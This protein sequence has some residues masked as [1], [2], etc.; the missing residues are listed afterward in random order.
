MLP[1]GDVVQAR[2]QEMKREGVFVKKVDLCIM[3]SIS[4][5]YFTF[6]LFGGGGCVR[7]QRTPAPTDL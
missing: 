7:T 4:N 1:Y 2:R 6:Y 3:Y 5:F